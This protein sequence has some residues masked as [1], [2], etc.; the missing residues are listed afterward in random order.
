MPSIDAGGEEPPLPQVTLADIEAAG[1]RLAGSIVRTPFLKSDTLSAITG[2][3]V[4]LKFENLQHTASFKE[5]GA[6]NRLLQ[7]TEQQRRGGVIAMSAGNHAQGLAYHATRL[8]IASTI[9]MPAATPFIKVENTRRLGAEVVLH[10]AGVEEAARHAVELG[11]RR[12]ATFIHPFDD[13]WII[14]GQGTVG[15]EM[16]DG[17][18]IELILVPIG[19]GGLA[20]GVALAARALAPAIEVIGVE[21]AVYPSVQR[22]LH[23]GPPVQGGPTIADGIAVKAP[24]AIT[25]PI[26]RDHLAGIELV[27]EADLEAAVLLL[28]EI[29]K[30]VVEGAGAAG[31]AAI[32]ARPARFAGRRCGVV[33]S[34]GNIDMRL[35]SGVILRGLVRSQRLVRLRVGLPDQPGSL[36]E[37]AQLI[38]SAGGNVVDVVHQRAFSRLGVKEA[39]VDLTIETR[40]RSHTVELLARLHRAGFQASELDPAR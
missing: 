27:T 1:R 33:L 5:R 8:A 15:L 31:L 6:L 37:V 25:L 3:E 38:A 32:L 9:V 14:A 26:L 34:G 10:G 21:A 30:T 22:L 36:A 29:E 16:L 2:A 23:G 12:G 40:D 11:E 20:S 24:G 4:Y 17:P 13:P 19:G 18:E 28:L 7:L 35:L 39:D